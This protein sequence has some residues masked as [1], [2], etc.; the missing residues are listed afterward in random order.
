[1]RSGLL[2]PQVRT[3]RLRRD[4]HGTSESTE[5]AVATK[6]EVS[7]PSGSQATP[8][9]ATRRARAAGG[10]LDYASYTCQ[11]GYVFAAAVTTSVTCPHCGDAQAW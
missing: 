8:D 6:P 5:S 7:R 4:R 10:P 3:R 11:C 1:M 9:V 2:Q